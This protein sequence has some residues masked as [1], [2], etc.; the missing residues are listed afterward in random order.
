[1]FVQVSRPSI[2]KCRDEHETLKT[3]SQRDSAAA[4]LGSVFVCQ[5]YRNSLR[6]FELKKGLT[7]LAAWCP[8]PHV[9][10]SS[11]RESHGAEKASDVIGGYM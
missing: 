3:H 9:R 10:M 1:M 6:D 4:Q 11:C 2:G 8:L 7:G 5:V